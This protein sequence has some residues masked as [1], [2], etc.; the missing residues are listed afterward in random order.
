MGSKAYKGKICIYCVRAE[1]STADHVI[2]RKFFLTEKREGIPKVPAC[3]VCNNRKSELE[4]YLSAVMLFGARHLDS[5]KTLAEQVPGR[6]ENNR[7]LLQTLRHG[8]SVERQ[9]YWEPYV[10]VPFDSERFVEYMEMVV[11]G[12]AWHY[13]KLCFDH[14]CMVR[15]SMISEYGAQLMEQLYRS[16]N[17]DRIAEKFS[18]GAFTFEAVRSTESSLFTAWRLSL[19][20]AVSVGD[21]DSPRER[22]RETHVV[23]CHRES[24]AVSAVQA[25]FGP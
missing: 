21:S 23:T 5:K 3:N 2:A 8:W 1:S 22:S 11:R 17:R 12:L 19:Y 10:T 7:K 16:K 9:N 13:W 20:G 15:G 25:L 6:L 14:N 24:R 4:H 18:N